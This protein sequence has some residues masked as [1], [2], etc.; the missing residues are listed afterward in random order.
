MDKRILEHLEIF[1]PKF[2]KARKLPFTDRIVLDYA[3]EELDHLDPLAL[4]RYIE[5]LVSAIT[6]RAQMTGTD[7]VFTFVFKMPPEMWSIVSAVWACILP[8]K[9]DGSL[10]MAGGRFIYQMSISTIELRAKWAAIQRDGRL[11]VF[12]VEYP[13]ILAYQ[14]ELTFE[15]Q[16]DDAPGWLYGVIKNIS[17]PKP[18]D[19]MEAVRSCDPGPPIIIKPKGDNSHDES[20]DNRCGCDGSESCPYIFRDEGDRPVWP[21]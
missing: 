15:P 8:P 18:Y 11:T 10:A 21:G 6:Y 5:A 13:V 14:D 4:V 1:K 20:G 12:G 7:G 9:N 2:V 17:L 19:G 16:Q 3:L